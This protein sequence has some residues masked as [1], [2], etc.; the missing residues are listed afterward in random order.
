MGQLNASRILND[1]RKVIQ[2]P[3]SSTRQEVLKT[4][5]W[6]C[7]D[8]IEFYD[9]VDGLC[10]PATSI[11]KRILDCMVPDDAYFFTATIDLTSASGTVIAVNNTIDDQQAYNDRMCDE[12]NPQNQ[13]FIFAPVIVNSFQNDPI[14]GQM[15]VELSKNVECY[16]SG[17]SVKI[18]CDSGIVLSANIVSTNNGQQEIILNGTVDL[19]AETNCFLAS[20]CNIS[21]NDIIERIKSIISGGQDSEDDFDGDCKNVAFEM[22]NEMI[23]QSSHPQV[24]GRLLRRGGEGTRSSLSDGAANQEIV[25]TAMGLGAILDGFTVE[26]LSAAALTVTV[27]GNFPNCKVS[28]N[29]NSDAATVNDLIAAIHADAA[30]RRLVQ[31]TTG[32]GDGTGLASALAETNLAGGDG[33]G[34]GVHD[35]SES[36]DEFG[37][38]KWILTHIRPDERNGMKEPLAESEWL[39]NDYRS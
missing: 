32:A 12:A 18:V 4:G 31:V 3:A 36:L 38:L 28:V 37:N 16:A 34:A 20:C 6:R 21:L 27:S 26:I 9:S 11:G 17:D 35:Y 1:S 29:N 10:L 33:T 19:S 15:R 24:D 39:H 14:G 25:F 13:P 30:A 22:T 8:E 23:S 5:C 7:G 2:N